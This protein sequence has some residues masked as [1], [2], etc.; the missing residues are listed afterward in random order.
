MLQSYLGHRSAGIHSRIIALWGYRAVLQNLT[1]WGLGD[2]MQ[3]RSHWGVTMLRLTQM[4]KFSFAIVAAV[5]R[6]M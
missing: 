1:N 3:K 4:V 2:E 6:R 5:T